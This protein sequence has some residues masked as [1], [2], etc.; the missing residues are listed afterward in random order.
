MNNSQA[1]HI[2]KGKENKDSNINIVRSPV[3][4]TSQKKK[5]GKKCFCWSFTT[6]LND[7]PSKQTEH[8]TMLAKQEAPH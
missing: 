8:E 7:F 3:I 6:I 5:G 1:N 2:E 4:L